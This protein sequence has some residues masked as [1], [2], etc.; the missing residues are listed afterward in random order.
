[1]SL[2]T[3]WL[4]AITHT[5]AVRHHGRVELAVVKSTNLRLGTVHTN[6]CGLSMKLTTIVLLATMALLSTL[7]RVRP[8]HPVRLTHPVRAAGAAVA[9]AA[10][11][12][13]PQFSVAL[14]LPVA[15][16]TSSC[17]VA[18]FSCSFTQLP[19]IAEVSCIYIFVPYQ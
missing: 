10:V 3:H 6:T 12:V 4:T 8:T 19:A 17:A 2:T 13:V 9:V 15:F 16:D 11:V 18:S 1:V 5:H 7:E 14:A